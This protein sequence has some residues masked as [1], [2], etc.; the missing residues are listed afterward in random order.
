LALFHEGPS[1]VLVAVKDA[2]A[3]LE[4]A[5]ESGVPA[6]MIGRSGGK[7]L[8]ISIGAETLVDLPIDQ[9]YS[10]WDGSLEE[11]LHGR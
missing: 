11:A 1:R 7:S 10:T 5:A 2:A 3:V 8:K 4:R 6:M 9:L